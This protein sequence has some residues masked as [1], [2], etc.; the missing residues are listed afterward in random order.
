MFP[1]PKPFRRDIRIPLSWLQCFDEP[2]MNVGESAVTPDHS[3]LIAGSALFPIVINGVPV[4]E[5]AQG[6]I[7]KVSLS[8]SA[9]VKAYQPGITNLLQGIDVYS[10]SGVALA[11]GFVT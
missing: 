7:F 3:L 11:C 8:R 1:F 10:T 2:S 9:S 6:T 5:R 4:E